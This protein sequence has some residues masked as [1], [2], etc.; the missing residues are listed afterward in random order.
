MFFGDLNLLLPDD[1]DNQQVLWKRFTEALTQII[2]KL[3][4]VLCLKAYL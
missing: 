4:V 2:D 3:K 1:Q